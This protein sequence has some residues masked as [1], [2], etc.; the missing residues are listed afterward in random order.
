MLSSLSFDSNRRGKVKR[1]RVVSFILLDTAISIRKQSWCFSTS[2]INECHY[3][4][5]VVYNSKINTISKMLNAIT[6]WL[7]LYERKWCQ[8]IE[9]RFRYMRITHLSHINRLG[10]EHPVC[11]I[12]SILCCQRTR[13]AFKRFEN[14]RYETN[15]ATPTQSICQIE[16]SLGENVCYNFRS[17][18]VLLL[19]WVH[20]QLVIWISANGD[21]LCE[22][23]PVQ[24][25]TYALCKF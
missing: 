3:I 22:R 9:I 24:G 11:W 18:F 1:R 20:K 14:K 25:H 2:Q 7:I 23:L 16:F 5:C 17:I 15:A 21:M 12:Y 6:S 13:F 4:Q 10:T 8:S 19:L